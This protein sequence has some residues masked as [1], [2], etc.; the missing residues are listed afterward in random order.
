MSDEL[1]ASSR[2]PDPRGPVGWIYARKSHYN[3]ADRRGR[4]LGD[5]CADQIRWGEGEAERQGI[6]VGDRYVDD[7]KS[8]S[9]YAHERYRQREDF[10]RM[11]ADIESG[12]IRPGDQLIMWN[13]N[14]Q[15]RD[16]EV[17]V[18]IRKMCEQHGVLWNVHGRIYDMRDARDR[19][20][21]GMDALRSEAEVDN[22][23]EGVRRGLAGSARRGRP[24]WT[25][26][27]Y[28]YTKIFDDRG[29]LSKIVINESEAT[30]LRQAAEDIA[31]GIALRAVVEQLNKAGIPAPLGGPWHTTSMRNHLLN[32]RYIGRGVYHG[33]VLE[34]ELEGGRA[35][36][37]AILDED[38]FYRCR[39][40]LTDP[41]RLN[42]RPTRLKYLLTGIAVCDVCD[43]PVVAIVVR[44]KIRS[45]YGCPSG[46]G[47]DG[48]GR[49]VGRKIAAV[50]QYVQECLFWRLSRPD[51]REWL[52]DDQGAGDQIAKLMTR[53]SEAQAHLA[54]AREAYAR[55]EI[56]L[57]TMSAAETADRAEVE[58][59]EVELETLRRPSVAAGLVAETPE[60]VA[61][62]WDELDLVQQ[63]G[64]LRALTEVRIKRIGRGRRLPV[65]ESVDVSFSRPR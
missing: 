36:W 49:H 14:R 9:R 41:S 45:H 5:S 51:A 34:T 42:A 61:A 21:T 12:R 19:Y 29:K 63:R 39:A 3:P 15:D 48:P 38:L 62:R 4:D 65:R 32:P 64:V 58:A 17:Y 27:A 24:H 16:L 10:E 30:V 56:S 47:P 2:T 44:D 8:A 26:K 33:E 25:K 57:A 20:Y 1:T 53:I 22:L 52:G 37:P 23:V 18:R 11:I 6:P 54:E 7:S 31:A 46:L 59:A 40:V 13:Q 35:M 55:R 50:D 28:G 43:G 60:E